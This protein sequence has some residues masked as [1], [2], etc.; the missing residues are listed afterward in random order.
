MLDT[1][2]TL[3]ICM[4]A[5]ALMMIALSMI[6]ITNTVNDIFSGPPLFDME[7]DEDGNLVPHLR[8]E[9]AEDDESE[10]ES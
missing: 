5:I 6:T 3:G 4:G 8:F 7:E 1:L 9:P 10:L 2:Q